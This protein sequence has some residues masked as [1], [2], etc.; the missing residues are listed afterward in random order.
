MVGSPPPSLIR[1][2]RVRMKQSRKH[3]A[4]IIT[5]KQEAE[6]QEAGSANVGA[7]L[8]SAGA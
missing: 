1:R 5:A 2:C 8:W 4:S 6:K 7:T 3:P